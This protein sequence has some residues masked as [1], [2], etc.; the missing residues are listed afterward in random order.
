M[1]KLEVVEEE[2]EEEK[3]LAAASLFRQA[4]KNHGYVQL[5]IIGPQ[6]VG[7]TTY[8]L[9]IA[10][11]VYRSL[12]PQLTDQEV[13]DL[14]LDRLFFDVRPSIALFRWAR[15]HGKRIPLVIYDDVGVHL[16]KYTPFQ[17]GGYG[18]VKAVASLF[19][20]IRTICNGVIITS[21]KL[22]SIKAVQE[23]SWYKAKIFKT[24]DGLIRQA[25]VWEYTEE[26][27][28]DPWHSCIITDDFYL[29][30]PPDVRK[31]YE[32]KRG[33][34]VDAILDECERALTKTPRYTLNCCEVYEL[35]RECGN[36]RETARRLNKPYS[37]I[38]GALDRHR[39]HTGMNDD[40]SRVYG[41]APGKI[42]I[43]EES[44]N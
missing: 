14:V 41:N 13:W 31:R 40:A 32:E 42:H 3:G 1:V 20:T 34:T 4:Y 12:H 22:H 36:L 10:W 18:V 21:P 9:Q 15:Q 28:G 6:G 2:V 23:L 29:W 8:S 30:L 19:D 17:K 43:P 7:K 25:K 44:K 38:Q 33:E 35:Y 11:E 26:V 16:S 39:R 27:W 5:F 24:D 37:T